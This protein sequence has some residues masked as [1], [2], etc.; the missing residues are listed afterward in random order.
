MLQ[1][2]QQHSLILRNDMEPASSS[3]VSYFISK[4]V[5]GLAGISGGLS[6]S[7]FWL[8]KRFK[9]KGLLATGAIIGGISVGAATT[10]TGLVAKLLGLDM[11]NFDIAMGLG[12]L[13][14]V[15]SLAFLFFLGS[16]FDAK[17][18]KNEN[19]HDIAKDIRGVK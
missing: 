5:T 18:R 13:V 2:S 17:E 16:Y 6:I 14:G 19:L 15:I 3:L 8:P 12:W 9:E 7:F 4:I 11:N 10:L 1:T